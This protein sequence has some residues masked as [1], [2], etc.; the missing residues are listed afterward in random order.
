MEKLNTVAV[1]EATHKGDGE[2]MNNCITRWQRRPLA[3]RRVC[4]WIQTRPRC[5]SSNAKNDRAFAVF[6]F[7]AHKTC[8]L[9]CDKLP[10][11][12]LH[13]KN[14]LSRSCET[15]PPWPWDGRARATVKPASLST[16]L[17]HLTT[18]PPTCNPALALLFA[19]CRSKI[20]MR[21]RSLTH[22]WR[23]SHTSIVTVQLMRFR[24][25]PN[26]VVWRTIMCRLFLGPASAHESDELARAA[27]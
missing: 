13:D 26:R 18:S 5:D 27:G 22:V 20:P 14:R 23:V 24:I 16:N 21:R 15:R 7:R 19:R 12:L 2:S 4:V 10:R 1:H 25:V 11:W 8:K 9:T 3:H 17:R 6:R